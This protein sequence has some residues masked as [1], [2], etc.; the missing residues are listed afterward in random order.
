MSYRALQV[1][2]RLEFILMFPFVLLGKIAGYIFKLSTPHDIF[3]FFP[4]ADIGGSPQVNIDITHCIRNRN[5]I[6]IYSKKGKNN[7][8]QD[9]FKAEGVRILDLSP[10]IDK[11][12][13][14]F[15][16]FFFRGVLS[17]WIN[18]A[19][20]PVILGGE[21]IFFYKMLPHLAK[22]TRTIEVCHLDTWLHYSIGFIQ[23]ID[24]RVFSTAYLKQQVIKQY[25]QYDLSFYEDKLLFS[26]NSIP[27]PELK[28]THNTPV[29][30]YF[31]GRGSPQKRVHLA[32]AIAQKMFDNNINAQLNFVGDVN[33]IIDEDDFP[34]CKFYGNVSDQ[35]QMEE[36]YQKAD[37]LLLTSAFEGLPMVIIKMMAYGKV[38][39]STAVN[40]IPDY[41]N[42]DKNGILIF[43]KEENE[44]VDEAYAQLCKLVASYDKRTAL[45]TAAYNFANTKFSYEHFC[46]FYQ[47]LILSKKT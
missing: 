23:Y 18:K 29:K 38:V 17:T 45:G 35:I 33:K 37:I 43:S 5:P 28:L 31:I 15:I 32:T 8:F 1:K 30:V 24:F 47:D 20:A 41:I 4:N 6:I 16:N 44:I 11:K 39:V 10:W 9:R 22:K 25:K 27:I 36:H 21:C 12:W 19:N 34:F 2:L 13:L 42:H 46:S 26:D 3:L 7:L 14:H 40:G